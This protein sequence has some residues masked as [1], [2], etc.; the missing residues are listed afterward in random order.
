MHLGPAADV[1]RDLRVHRPAAAGVSQELEKE[2]KRVADEEALASR[3]LRY[4][5]DVGDR[6]WDASDDSLDASLVIRGP[7]TTAALEGTWEVFAFYVSMNDWDG[8]HDEIEVVLP[9][10]G[11]L[12]IDESGAGVVDIP[13]SRCPHRPLTGTFS[14]EILEDVGPRPYS[15]K[16]C[17]RRQRMT[18]GS[19]SVPLVSHSLK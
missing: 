15:S 8:D 14:T 12:S 9:S 19:S 11:H 7:K 13:R 4:K 3:R 16:G 10:A 1:P 2:E 5:A 6:F 17:F 18:S